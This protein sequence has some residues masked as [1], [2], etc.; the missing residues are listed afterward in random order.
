MH[1]KDALLAIKVT[2]VIDNFLDRFWLLRRS[3][4]A[5]I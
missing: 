3:Y 4:K 5:L 2:N 1:I